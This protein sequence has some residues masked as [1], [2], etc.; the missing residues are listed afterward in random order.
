MTKYWRAERDRKKDRD[1]REKTKSSRVACVCL[2]GENT[3]KTHQRKGYQRRRALLS[4]IHI[5]GIKNCI[6]GDA[7]TWV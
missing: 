3:F 5:R 4:Y 7:R 6:N 2:A 1:R